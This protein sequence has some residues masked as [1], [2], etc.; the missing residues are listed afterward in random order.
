[1]TSNAIISTT[2]KEPRFSTPRLVSLSHVAHVNL[3][4]ALN[5][6]VVL[7]LCTALSRPGVFNMPGVKARF[8]AV[9]RCLLSV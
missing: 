1:M 4:T 2:S 5:R 3:C 9:S 7:R 6:P 8:N